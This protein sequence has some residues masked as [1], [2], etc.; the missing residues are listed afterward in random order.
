MK[1]VYIIETET[2]LHN[3]IQYHHVSQEGYSNLDEAKNFI[4][5][6]CDKP[7]AVTDFIFRSDR[8]TYTIRPITIRFI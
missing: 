6:R 8:L 1:T 4:L 3:P 7:E 2:R 5:S